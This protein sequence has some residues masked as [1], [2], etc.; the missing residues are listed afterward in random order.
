MFTV[1]ISNQLDYSDFVFGFLN[2]PVTYNE[3]GLILSP[4]TV[5]REVIVP[6]SVSMN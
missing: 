5:Y 3:H 2:F 6:F 1:V 4:E